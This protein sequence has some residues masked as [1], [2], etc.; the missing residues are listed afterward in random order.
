MNLSEK[1]HYMWWNVDF[2]V[3]AQDKMT[4]DALKDDNLTDDHKISNDQIQIKSDAYR[5]LRYKMNNIDWLGI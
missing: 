4:T 5:F 2:S 1:C 3:R